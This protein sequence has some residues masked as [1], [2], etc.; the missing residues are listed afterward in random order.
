MDGIRRGRPPIWD[1]LTNN[2][3]YWPPACLHAP[4]VMAG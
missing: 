1:Y 4:A 3:E 2:G